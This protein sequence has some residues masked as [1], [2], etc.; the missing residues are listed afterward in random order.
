M[1]GNCGWIPRMGLCMF[2]TLTLVGLMLS[3]IGAVSRSGGILQV[4]STTKTD[5]YSESLASVA[6]FLPT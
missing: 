6:C 3:G 2:I 1:R 4:V 5:T